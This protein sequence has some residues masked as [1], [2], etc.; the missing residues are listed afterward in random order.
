MERSRQWTDAKWVVLKWPLRWTRITESHSLLGHRED[1]PVAQD[2]RVVDQDVELA[3]RRDGQVDEGA[4]GLEVGH[5]AE[6]RDRPAARRAD[7]F[8]DVLR[9][10]G[11]RLARAVAARAAVVVDDDRRAEPGEFQGFR[12]AQA[13]ARAGDDRAEALKWE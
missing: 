9:G 10:R 3:V 8:G 5:V 6:V 2:A 11:G 7:L 12:P 13:A 4:R 1:H